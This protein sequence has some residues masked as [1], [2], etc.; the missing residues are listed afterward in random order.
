VAPAVQPSAPASTGL[1]TPI[2]IEAPDPQPG[3]LALE[4][5]S[6]DG[7]V[8]LEWS[9]ST[10]DDFHHYTGLRSSQ[11]DISPAY[12]PISPAVDWGGTY[13]TDRFIVSAVDGSL[14][15]E[16]QEWFY[17]VMSYD[18]DNRVLESSPV[19]AAELRPAA[20]LGTLTVGAEAFG[21]ARIRWRPYAGPAGCFS[22]YR[23]LYGTNGPPTTLLTTV[24]DRQSTS[25]ETTSL[26]STGSYTLR[27]DAVRRTPLGSIVVA[28]SDV[29][30]VTP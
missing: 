29:A 16:E 23:V 9:A 8:V 10:D 3:A 30:T 17:R 22:E 14:V 27:V 24:S 15:A 6:C 1:A 18:E 4:A 21:D 12:P 25:L 28:R 2:A 5:T 11:L 13:A 20:Q 7:G 26:P 19:V